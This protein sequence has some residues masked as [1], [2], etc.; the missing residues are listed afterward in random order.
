MLYR[1]FIISAHYTCLLNIVIAAPAH[2]AYSL[3]NMS[4]IRSTGYT[5]SSILVKAHA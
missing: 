1:D 5:V 4:M 3:S 2:H